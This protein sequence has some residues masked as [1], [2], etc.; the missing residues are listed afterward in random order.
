MFRENPPRRQCYRWQKRQLLDARYRYR[1][2]NQSENLKIFKKATVNKQTDPQYEDMFENGNY[3]R[4][5]RMKRPY[6]LSNR[7][8]AATTMMNKSLFNQIGADSIG[9]G[10]TSR[11]LFSPPNYPPWVCFFFI[12]L[13][14][15]I[16]WSMYIVDYKYPISPPSWLKSDDE[17]WTEVTHVHWNRSIFLVIN[18]PITS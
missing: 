3:K 16:I 18:Y 15:L 8:A 5:R 12:Y 1:F 9:I 2:P 13:F 10:L 7:A 11:T 4:R 14:F 17:L 6:S